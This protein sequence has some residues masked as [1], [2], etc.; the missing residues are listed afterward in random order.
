MQDMGAPAGEERATLTGHTGWVLACAISPNSHFIVTPSRD[1]TCR[2][3]DAATGG[4]ARPSPGTPM[5]SPL[6]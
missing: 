3:W 6:V 4:S 1:R 2:I 5:E